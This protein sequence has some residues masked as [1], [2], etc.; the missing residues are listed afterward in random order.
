MNKLTI[1]TILFSV[2]FSSCY[3][4]MVDPYFGVY[5]TKIDSKVLKLERVSIADTS[6]ALISGAIYSKDGTDTL[7]PNVAI[8]AVVI[9]IDQKTG[10]IYAN[11]TDING[12]YQIHLPTS[13]YNLKVGYTDYQTLVVRD[14]ILQ[15]G[16]IIE[17]NAQLGLSIGEKDSSVYAMQA[18]KTIKL[19]SRP[20]KP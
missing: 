4:K 2:T 13:I 14:V 11:L 3:R 10:K 1:F 5:F 12:K 7:S 9:I 19:I 17:F 16:E 8:D 18:D 15:A 20:I 6:I